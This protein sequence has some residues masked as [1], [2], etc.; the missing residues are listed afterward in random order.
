MNSI[1]AKKQQ[2]DASKRR[3]SSSYHHSGFDVRRSFVIK[4]LCNNS[5]VKSFLTNKDLEIIKVM[6]ESSI[7]RKIQSAEQIR[8]EIDLILSR[9]IES[10]SAFFQFSLE[11]M[12][13]NIC[14]QIIKFIDDLIEKR[15]KSVFGR[16]VKG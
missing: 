6:A 15:R 7:P 10:K 3:K 12:K 4:S 5:T 11:A 13:T 14:N 2:Q 16:F 8:D 9:I 1:T